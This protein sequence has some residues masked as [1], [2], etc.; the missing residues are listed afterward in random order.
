[1]KTSDL[2]QNPRLGRISG[3]GANEKRL[4]GCLP[5]SRSLHFYCVI[6]IYFF[7]YALKPYM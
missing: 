1:M 4:A 7:M 2:Q 6:A 5:A 3:W